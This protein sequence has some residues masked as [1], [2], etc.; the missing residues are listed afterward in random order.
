MNFLRYDGLPARII[1]Y[2]WTLFLLNICLILCSAPIVTIGASV[3]AAHSVFLQ[4]TPQS[5]VICKF[6]RAFRENLKQATAI[7]LVFLVAAILLALD[8]YCLLCYSFPGSAIAIVTTAILS[9]V[10]LSVASYVFPLQAKF[11]NPVRST[12]KNAVILG[13]SRMFS[14]LLMAFVSLLPVIAFFIDLDIFLRL[15]AVWFP[16]GG[17]LQIRINS[18][19]AAHV[20]RKVQ[21]DYPPTL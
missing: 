11:D 20:F 10:Y 4:A 2:V 21:P 7:Y 8:W 9:A 12:M 17:A 16:L 6:F 1:C 18:W 19:I 3:T 14:G 13:V 15:L 5:G